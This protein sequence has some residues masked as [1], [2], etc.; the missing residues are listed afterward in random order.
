M[1]KIFTKRDSWYEQ[2]FL[3]MAYSRMCQKEFYLV[4]DSDTIPIKKIEMFD[5]LNPFFD[6]K[7]E[8]HIPYFNTMELLI[9][10]LHFFNRS[11]ISE[12]MMIK[13]EYMKNLLDTLEKNSKIP[14][15]LFWEKI[16]MAIDIKDINGSGFSE[17]ETYGSFVDTFYPKFYKHRIW[18]SKRD[19]NA[20]YD[21][22]LNLDSNDIKWLSQDYDAITF[23]KWKKFEEDNL[24]IVKDLKLQKIYGPKN[25]F[26][27]FNNLKRKYKNL[28]KTKIKNVKTSR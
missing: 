22:A 7:T 1:K 24:G 27:H 2:Q 25:F 23:E 16:L 19:A 28:T 3:K 13:T 8:H 9:P 10:G 15:K 4:W 6:M 26:I 18:N 12:H 5:N 20:F 21:N 17:F 11:Y 14:G